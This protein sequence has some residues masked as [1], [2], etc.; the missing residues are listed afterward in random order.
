MNTSLRLMTLAV[1]GSL[2]GLTGC[3][4]QHSKP[5]T[6]YMPDMVYSPAFK[7]QEE[8]FQKP[9]VKGTIPRGYQP[10]AYS[11]SMELAGKEL[12]NPLHRSELTLARGKDRF[13]TYCIVCHGEYGEGD[14]TVVPK[15]PRPPS[16]QSDKIRGYQDGQIYHVITMGQ[17]SMPSYASQIDPADRW[18]IIHYVRALQ[19]AKKP[20]PGDVKV[21]AQK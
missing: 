4:V 20:L 18:A 13:N 10:Y 15:Y 5:N 16:L 9:P 21:A 6:V 11:A 2:L 14:G 1:I 7:A 17:N 8:G 3:T 19:R 12:K